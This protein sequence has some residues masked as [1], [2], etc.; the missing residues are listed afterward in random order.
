[1][2]GLVDV[3]LGEETLPNFG[4]IGPVNAGFQTNLIC[5][6]DDDFL[7]AGSSKTPPEAVAEECHFQAGK[8]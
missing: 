3:D 7:Q 6:E 1:M 5:A 8:R 2:N 4:S